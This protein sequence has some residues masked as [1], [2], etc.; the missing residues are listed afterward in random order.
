MLGMLCGLVH[1][2]AR[3]FIPAASRW[4]RKCQE[5]AEAAGAWGE[6]D[7]AWT[8][9]RQDSFAAVGQAAASGWILNIALERSLYTPS[10]L[11][12]SSP[13]LNPHSGGTHHRF[14]ASVDL[15]SLELMHHAQRLI[16]C[17][18]LVV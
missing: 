2:P 1:A 10:A 6:R 4:Y 5:A 11:W 14:S 15:K 7:S 13:D 8:V 18:L 17:F 16:K 12:S 3:V 9:M